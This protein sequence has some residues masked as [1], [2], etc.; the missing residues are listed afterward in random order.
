MLVACG[1][2]LWIPLAEMITF[3]PGTPAF[4]GERG[5]NPWCF[6]GKHA[7]LETP[8]AKPRKQSVGTE[9]WTAI[10]S[11]S[12][13]RWAHNAMLTLDRL[14]KSSCEGSPR[15]EASPVERS[16]RCSIINSSAYQ[17][18]CLG[19]SWTV[20]SVYLTDHLFVLR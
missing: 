3:L 4:P 19:F 6:L 5:L 8:N 16:T 10:W 13:E 17:G 15:K 9:Y 12:M 1:L 20:F 2:R 14:A 18:S 7:D 11:E